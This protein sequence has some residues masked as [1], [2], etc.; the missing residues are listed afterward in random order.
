MTHQSVT[1]MS[2]FFTL[3]PTFRNYHRTISTP[4][5]SIVNA[6]DWPGNI[7]QLG[8][9]ENHKG[10]FIKI[11]SYFVKVLVPKIMIKSA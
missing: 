4:G 6:D 5:I 11:L 3:K 9:K 10:F 7:H 8:A 2:L 1:V